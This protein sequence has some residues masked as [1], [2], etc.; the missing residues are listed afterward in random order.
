MMQ[1]RKQV[2]NHSFE[3]IGRCSR[4]CTQLVHESKRIWR[5]HMHTLHT[6]AHTHTHTLYIGYVHAVQ[7]IHVSCA[8]ARVPT[9]RVARRGQKQVTVTKVQSEQVGGGARA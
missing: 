8:P 3:R 6:H 7:C 1:A 2:N 4:T 9:A 5:E